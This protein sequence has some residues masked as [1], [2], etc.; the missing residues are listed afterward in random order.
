MLRRDQTSQTQGD[1]LPSKMLA[2]WNPNS[3]G[4]DFHQGIGQL[5]V[6]EDQ[7]FTLRLEP[8]GTPQA[9]EDITVTAYFEMRI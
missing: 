6:R 9:L 7:T 5:T 1:G 4:F 3:L 2:G 8:L